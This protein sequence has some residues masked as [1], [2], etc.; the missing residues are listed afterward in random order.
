MRRSKRLRLGL[1]LSVGLGPFVMIRP[2]FGPVGENVVILGTD[3][4]GTWSVEF[5]GT[6]AKF[7]VASNTEIR[8]VVPPGATT[9]RVQVM[10]PADALE[11]NVD[12]VVP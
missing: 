3:L 1:Q 6:P 12:F 5:N 10:T 4:G 11:S 8:A 7:V 2:T 9:G